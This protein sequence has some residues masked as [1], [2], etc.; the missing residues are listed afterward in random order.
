MNN[1]LMRVELSWNSFSQ[2]AA[3][4]VSISIVLSNSCYIEVSARSVLTLILVDKSFNLVL[5][6]L[7]IF[8]SASVD[9][10][11]LLETSSA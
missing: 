6:S 9:E 11:S 10:S 4:V 5:K 1:Y 2:A 8:K 7:M 3:S